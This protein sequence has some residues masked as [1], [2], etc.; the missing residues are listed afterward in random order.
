MQKEGLLLLQLRLDVQ[1]LSRYL[2]QLPVQVV[3]DVFFFQLDLSEYIV[4]L[5]LDLLQLQ[6]QLVAYKFL[7]SFTLVTLS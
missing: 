5:L 1:A 2:C 4:L 7:V 3:I 6:G